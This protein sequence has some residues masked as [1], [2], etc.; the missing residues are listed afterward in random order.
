MQSTD[1]SPPCCWHLYFHFFLTS[2]LAATSQ[3]TPCQSNVTRTQSSRITTPASGNKWQLRNIWTPFWMESG[4]KGREIPGKVKMCKWRSDVQLYLETSFLLHHSVCFVWTAHPFSTQA[5]VRHLWQT[6]KYWDMNVSSKPLESSISGIAD[7]NTTSF[8]VYIIWAYT[9]T[10][11]GNDGYL[12]LR[13]GLIRCLLLKHG[14]DNQ[15]FLANRRTMSYL[16]PTT[17][18]F[19]TFNHES[20]VCL[21]QK[22]VFL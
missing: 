4:G 14:Q 13:S 9:S 17:L 21:F 15:Q 12:E 19:T 5:D 3:K 20:S 2:L 22:H 18:L 1:T 11:L 8:K 16:Y 10:R 7:L 6:L